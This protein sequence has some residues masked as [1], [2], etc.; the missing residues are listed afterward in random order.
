MT[1]FL[2][3]STILLKRQYLMKCWTEFSH[4]QSEYDLQMELFQIYVTFFHKMTIQN[5]RLCRY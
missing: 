5:G 4:I 3:T 1:Y 2:F